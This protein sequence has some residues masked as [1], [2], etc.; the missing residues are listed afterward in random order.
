MWHVPV[1]ASRP[2]CIGLSVEFEV[3]IKWRVADIPPASGPRLMS[4][5]ALNP[6]NV[7]SPEIP[8]GWN[9][10]YAITLVL[11]TFARLS[12]YHCTTT[13]PLPHH[14][15]PLSLALK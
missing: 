12:S 7:T 8:D 9:S 5:W 14:Q 11:A 10:P 4:H 2:A 1:V 15:A 6:I 3:S 13:I